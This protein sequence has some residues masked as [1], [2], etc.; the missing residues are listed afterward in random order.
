MAT[1]TIELEV[2]E[3]TSITVNEDTLIVELM[4]SRTLSVP[5]DWYPRLVHATQ[6]ERNT[7]ELH[8]ESGHIHWEAL[9]QD[10]SVEGLLAGL[11][12]HLSRSTHQ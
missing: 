4:D 9:D 6:E 8:N 2:P 1:S 11:H 7:W 5:L 12:Q 10:M 3:A